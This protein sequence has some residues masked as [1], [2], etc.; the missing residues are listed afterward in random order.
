MGKEDIGR[1]T[2]HPKNKFGFGS[3]EY[4]RAEYE[5]YRVT[6]EEYWRLWSKNNPMCPNCGGRTDCVCQERD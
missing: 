1:R 4:Y 5:L 3:P 6:S 2:H